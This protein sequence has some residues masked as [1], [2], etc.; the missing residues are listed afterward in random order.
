MTPGYF[1]TQIASRRKRLAALDRE[2]AVL[3]GELTA[4]EDALARSTDHPADP[5]SFEAP[6][7]SE[8]FLPV[9]RAWLIILER[10]TTFPHF[11][12]N[13][14]MLVARELH[15]EGKLKKPQ[16]NDG[17]RAQLSLYAKK[18]IIK[19]RGGGN[20]QL[21][22]NT[23]ARLEISIAKLAPPA[24]TIESLK[25]VWTRAGDSGPKHGG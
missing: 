25:P 22:E 19:R 20:Y 9:S 13:D 23:R 12:T 6:K 16:T 11:N 8:Q 3:V 5:T 18:G 24:R 7:E 21:T 14:L 1:E 2:R 10:L 17:V 4:Y 15:A